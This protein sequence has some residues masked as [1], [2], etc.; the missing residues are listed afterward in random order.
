MATS[1]KSLMIKL[2]SAEPARLLKT[3]LEQEVGSSTRIR[4]VDTPPA[5]GELSGP[6]AAVLLAALG[7]GG[8]AVTIIG[9]VFAWL[10]TRTSTV[11]VR[12][13][14]SDGAE[15]ELEAET[16]GR[17]APSD[18]PSIMEQLAAWAADESISD[19]QSDAATKSVL[20]STD[21]GATDTTSNKSELNGDLG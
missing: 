16:A 20:L 12:L 4:M 11:R 21:N 6:T 10:R 18:L 9:G 1:S 3:W 15:V 19:Y 8:V 13:I 14:R 5:A 2:E 17:I 7:P